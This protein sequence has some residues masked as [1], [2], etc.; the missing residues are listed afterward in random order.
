MVCYP[1]CLGR[2]SD[3]FVPQVVKRSTARPNASSVQRRAWQQ[4]CCCVPGPLLGLGASILTQVTE[5][6]EDASKNQ[7][8][9][10]KAELGLALGL[11][12]LVF[13]L[14]APTPVGM[15]P[16]AWRTTGVALLMATWW[17][18]E[19]IP[20]PATALVPLVVFPIL[21][22]RPIGATAAPY[23]DPVI[24]L[25]MGG[26]LIAAALQ[27]CGLHQRM[28]LTIITIGGVSPTRLVGAFMAATAFLSMWVSNTATAAMMMP[29]AM[30][31]L[32]IAKSRQSADDVG[33]GNLSVALLLGIAYSA[34]I[35]GLGTLI[36]TPPNAL[37]AGFMNETYGVQ[38]G[39]AQWMLLAVPV[40]VLA[41][42]IV[43]W[44][45]TRV[46]YP[47][48]RD[49]IAGGAAAIADMLRGL[50][51]PSRAE[52]TVGIITALTAG[53]W[54]LRPLLARSVPSLSDAGIAMAGALLLFLVPTDKGTSARALDWVSAERLPWGVLILFGGGLSLAGAIQGTGLAEWMGEGMVGLAGWPALIV[55]AIVTLSIV[56]MTELTSNTA[57][58]AALLPVVAALA[59]AVG[60]D[61]LRLAAPAALA[62][63]CAFMMPVAT[64]A[65][66]IVYGTGEVSI[67]QMVRAGA[68]VNIML[69]VIVVAVT[70]VAVPLVFP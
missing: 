68:V 31:V 57:T 61:P 23:A 16:E 64:P 34:S 25:F 37:L 54:I 45:L 3:E 32:V 56:L 9:R 69:W 60:L 19:A 27:R 51:R 1:Q 24:F 62:A 7:S 30:S 67:A 18:T 35:G 42:P 63:T 13:T 43:W 39:F 10:R 53:A 44:V 29:I 46:V 4:A 22:V 26:F 49:P 41:L 12:L 14:V 59:L 15:S 8:G 28:A 5:E 58:A 17:V 66:A 38:V 2:L 33:T 48:G 52:W 36:G 6:P 21:G 55:V 47:I 50:G 70:F 20:I 65:N 11:F 40:V